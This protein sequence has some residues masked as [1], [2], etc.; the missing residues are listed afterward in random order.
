MWE[1]SLGMGVDFT[2]IQKDKRWEARKKFSG[3]RW[4][5]TVGKRYGANQRE[6]I[7]FGEL[8]E[9]GFVCVSVVENGG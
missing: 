4:E 1:P 6:V 8:L 5:N 2:D 9:D 7:F 3:R